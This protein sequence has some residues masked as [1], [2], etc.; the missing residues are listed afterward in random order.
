MFL[1]LL[2]LTQDAFKCQVDVYWL[3]GWVLDTLPYGSPD[4]AQLA[5]IYM[6]ITLIDSGLN[7]TPW[8]LL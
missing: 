4:G 3:G 6:C 8:N 2:D 1:T 5:L 7:A